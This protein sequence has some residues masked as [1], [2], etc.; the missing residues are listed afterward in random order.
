MVQPAASAGP[1]F[2]ASITRGKFHGMICC[3]RFCQKTMDFGKSRSFDKDHLPNSSDRLVQGVGKKIAF[4]GKGFAFNLIGPASI[5]PKALDCQI[6]IR[7][8]AIT[9]PRSMVTK[10]GK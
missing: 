4:N 1:S 3:H 5:I 2:H 8:A 10:G 6:Q 7:L 9:W